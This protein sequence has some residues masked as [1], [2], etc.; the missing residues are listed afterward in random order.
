MIFIGLMVEDQAKTNCDVTVLWIGAIGH[1]PHE[2]TLMDG[3]NS[4]GRWLKQRRRERDLTQEQLADHIGSSPE[5][6][7]KIE[8]GRRRPSTQ[9]VEVIA[10]FFGVPRDEWPAIVQFARIG[11]DSNDAQSPVLAAEGL[12]SFLEG[13]ARTNLPAERTTFVGRANEVSRVQTLLRDESVRILTLTGPPGIGKTRLAIRASTGLLADF[14]HGVFFV[15]LSA[16]SDP[17]MVIPAICKT[18]AV[19]EVASQPLADLLAS[20]MRDRRM[21]L[22]LD[23]FEQVIEAAQA[24]GELTVAC[25]GLKLLVTSRAV[26]RIYGEHEFPV[27]VLSL[28]NR[29]ETPQTECA[30]QYEA[31]ELF[32]QRSRAVCPDFTLNEQELPAVVEICRQLDGLPLAIEL[33]AARSKLLPPG[34]LLSRLSDKLGLLVVGMRDLPAR[35]RTLR[36]AIAWSYDLL[37]DDERTL[38]RWFSVFVSAATL[39]AVEVVCGDLR[40]SML[41]VRPATNETGKP[42]SSRLAASIEYAAQSGE[43]K[44]QN[45]KSSDLLEV[46][47]SLVDKSLLRQVEQTGEPRFW[48]LSTIREYARERLTESGEERAAKR[49]HA[50]YYAALAETVEPHLTSGGREPWLARLEAEYSNLRAA[51]AWC[52]SDEGDADMGLRI[53]GALGWFW[54]F[55]T[56]LS[57][58]RNWLD[59]AFAR[60]RDARQSRTVAKALNAAGRLAISQGDYVIACSLLQES[61]DT[62]R[63]VGDKEG[64]AYALSDLGIAAVNQ[65]ELLMG[66]T[67]IEEAVALFRDM[68]NNWGLAFALDRLADAKTFLSDA[69]GATALYAESLTLYREL[70]DK[71]GITRE[72]RDLGDRLLRLGEY[73]S[74]QAMLE[75]A[76]AIGREIGNTLW[77]ALLAR[78]LGD[79]LLLQCEFA[80][81]VSLYEEALDLNRELGDRMR[82]AGSLRVL[83]HATRCLGNFPRA[84]RLYGEALTLFRQL[85]DRRGMT[86]TLAGIA[87]LACQLG[88]DYT[89]ACLLGATA[90]ILQSKEFYHQVDLIE[91]ERNLLQ[92]RESLQAKDLNKAWE[93][94]RAMTIEQALAYAVA[95]VIIPSANPQFIKLSTVTD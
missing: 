45:P 1:P 21:L 65:G 88:L 61:V 32:V 22:V 50:S 94:G 36:G 37:D 2:E 3:P 47:S 77:I 25:P 43:A 76:L 79:T 20:Y 57:E 49:Y 90:V 82:T 89:A 24:L 28:P 64:L 30:G 67:L 18:L 33:A 83:G 54:F 27:P 48:M 11:F 42:T 12:R 56:Y 38:F 14:D 72:L 59:G 85:N 44:H 41:D 80:Q 46:L 7:R 39:Q 9:M 4:F 19:K 51:L 5:T 81:A 23:N 62:W 69:E 15:P 87:G 93:L 78:T 70:G 86:A 92:V 34:A 31:I 53:A 68:R 60:V 91:Y 29:D 95:E 66:R 55:R 26:L 58:G 10:G 8:A 35:Q 13:P 75:E 84:G 74:A 63:N 6:I 52:Q 40:S 17:L 73:R 16:I 71:W